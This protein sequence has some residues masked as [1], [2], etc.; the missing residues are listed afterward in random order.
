MNKVLHKYHLRR[1]FNQLKSQKRQLVLLQFFGGVL[2]YYD[3]F[4]FTFIFFFLLR[5]FN[6]HLIELYGIAI[7]SLISFIFRPLGYRIFLF[8]AQKYSRFAIITVNST[9]MTLSIA[10]TGLIPLNSAN[11]FWTT[12]CCLVVARIIHGISFG[13][14]LQANLFYI[15]RL[16]PQRIHTSLAVSIA[17]AQ[18]GLTL[19]MFVN[20]VLYEY[21]TPS[22][23][24]WAWRIPFF[25]GALISILLYIIR[26]IAYSHKREQY[27]RVEIC[28]PIDKVAFKSGSRLWLS[29]VIASSRACTIFTI[30]AIIPAVLNWLLKWNYTKITDIMV[31][32]SLTNAATT[33]IFQ[34][35]K[36]KLKHDTRTLIMVLALIIPSSICFGYGL[37]NRDEVFLVTSLLILSIINGYLFVVIPKFLIKIFSPSERLESLLFISN[38]EYF[39]FN[40]IRRGGLFVAATVFGS[41]IPTGHYIVILIGSLSITSL[42]SIIALLLINKRS[43]LAKH[44]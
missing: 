43:V 24:T 42:S 2:E 9:L 23:L 29:L 25:I 33:A 27:S 30:F 12:F 38:Y 14:K 32:A 40:L 18:L 41:F 5:F 44:P 31:V 37:L 39:H 28:L 16:F 13:I 36:F 20:K 17:G 19:A 22:Q 15:K 7:I 1:K 35:H 21:F 6:H 8:A 34:Q 26:M 10:A 3:F 4:S 11:N